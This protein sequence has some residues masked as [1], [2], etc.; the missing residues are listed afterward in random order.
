MVM[1]SGSCVDDTR[2]KEK[3]LEYVLASVSPKKRC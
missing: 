2:D 1:N 3:I